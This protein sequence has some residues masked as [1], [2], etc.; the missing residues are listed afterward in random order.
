MAIKRSQ[1]FLNQQRVDTPHLRSIESA[2]RNDFDDVAKGLLTGS[3]NSYFIRGFEINM[4][5]AIGSSSTS[6]Q[7][8]AAD[9]AVLHTQSNE[10]GTFFV[11]DSSEAN[12]T[13]SSTTNE[14]VEG[15][16]TPG[17]LNYVGIEFTREVDNSTTA[18]VYF[19]NPTIDV[20]FTKTVPL[21][22]TLS[23][24]FVISSSVFT[25]NVLPLAIIETDAANNVLSVEDRRHM[26]FRLG[27][28]GSTA[29]DPSYLYP[30]DEGREENDFKSTSSA[31]SPFVGGD[32]QIRTEKEWKDAVMSAIKEIKGTTYWYSQNVAGSLVK[33][34]QDIANMMMTGIGDISHSETIAGKIN[35]SDNINFN[36]VGSRLTYTLLA[37]PSTSHI[38]MSDDQAAYIKLVRGKAITPLLVF[39]NGSSV[40]SS[41]GAVSWTN[42]VVAGDFV[43]QASQLDTKY[44]KVLSVDSASQVTLS[45]PFL[46]LST[47]ISGTSAEY[48]WGSYLTDAAPSTDRHVKVVSRK[49]VP[50]DEDTYWLFLRQDNGGSLARV[51]VRGSGFGELEQGERREISDN[52]AVDVLE[53]IGSPSEH[54]STPDYTNSVVTAVLEQFVISFPPA[55]STTTGQYFLANSSGDVNEHYFWINKDG[56]GGNPLLPGKFA[57]AIAVSTGQPNTVVAAAAAIII[58]AITDFSA[59]DNLDGTVTVTLSTAGDSTDASNFNVG[60]LSIVTGIQGNGATNK[61][62]VDDENLTKSIKRLDQ[63]LG[64][65]VDSIS[66]EGYEEKIT[67]VSGAPANDN[68]LTGPIS[69]LTTFAIPLNARDSDIQQTYI[70]GSGTLA[71]YLNGVRL[72]VGSD[73]SEVGA[74]DS[75]S[76]QIQTLIILELDDLLVFKIEGEGAGGAGAGGTYSG[77]NLGTVS[78]AN[79]FKQLAGSQFQFRRLT[80]GSNVTITENANDIIISS[81]SGVASSNVSVKSSNYTLLST[82]DVI[83][84]DTSS[85]S[86]ILTLP[87]ATSVSGKKYDLKK[88]SALNSMFI[89]SILS[90]TLDGTNIDASPLDVTT[91]NESIT[92]VAGNGAWW[93]I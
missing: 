56:G 52:T 70:V 93:I 51:Y 55:N 3:D 65:F 38:V 46:E 5:G 45:T 61:F 81:S 9:S 15:S 91:N 69:A 47:G 75:S 42:D 32:K 27:T 13:L 58:D 1:N 71:I 8:L 89:K 62:V 48:A 22:Q 79:V 30:W 60:G 73:Y 44:Y 90:Q 25:S 72:F 34:K 57:H 50:F 54:V 88:I 28:A 31:A 2:V 85:G 49:D 18:Q 86:I 36:F 78:S 26:F 80:Q 16:F 63:A 84:A 76:Y 19:W 23:Y 14:K 35:W 10:S 68:Q 6:L 4:T 92:I 74:I 12:Q 29:P 41:V 53:Y 17:A 87:D 67:V 21:A 24:K 77:A 83:L 66:L 40:V 64:D 33:T 11:T 82:N 43:K 59:V 20:E 7:V 37:N 39:T